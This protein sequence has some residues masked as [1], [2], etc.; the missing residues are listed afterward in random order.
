MDILSYR[1]RRREKRIA[2]WA[3]YRLTGKPSGFY[4][5]YRKLTGHKMPK[6]MVRKIEG[7]EDEGLTNQTGPR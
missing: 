4:G 1:R 7:F 5:S 3:M 2:E 6:R